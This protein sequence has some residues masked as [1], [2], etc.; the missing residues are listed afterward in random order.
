MPPAALMSS[1][2]DKIPFF[3]SSPGSANLPVSG[4]NEP[5]SIG[6]FCC[7]RLAVAPSAT[8]SRTMPKMA[9]RVH[10]RRFMAI[11]LSSEGYAPGRARS[12]SQPLR[13]ALAVSQDGDGHG[14]ACCSGLHHLGLTLSGWIQHDG[15]PDDI[16]GNDAGGGLTAVARADTG[17]PVDLNLKSHVR[18]P[19][20]MLTGVD[21]GQCPIGILVVCRRY[22]AG[23]RRCQARNC[24]RRLARGFDRRRRVR[25]LTTR[26]AT[27]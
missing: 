27:L 2:A 6:S 18:F 11:L 22:N 4:R 17:F 15:E 16:Q 12:V 5:I 9:E 10:G 26:R 7:A 14:R 19:R 23:I 1:V 8:H 21:G 3:W 20:W 25:R 13:D 24:A